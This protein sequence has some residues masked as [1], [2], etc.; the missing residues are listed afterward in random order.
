MSTFEKTVEVAVP[1]NTAYN[2]WTQFEDFPYFMGGVESV[3]QLADDR[4]E[5]VV[6][7]GGVRR[8]W[9]AKILEQVPDRRI[10]WAATDGT[11]N[12]GLVEFDDLGDHTRVRLVMDFDPEGLVE[13][14]GEK[15]NVVE[16]RAERDLE[17]FKEFIEDE[18]Y[19]TGAWRGTIT[20]GRR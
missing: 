14:V 5:W 13:N 9:E 7:I 3:R 16:N 8:Q 17:K 12:S 19:A 4:L 18:G 2:Q 11:T 10:A 1:V 15:L 20:P 6:S